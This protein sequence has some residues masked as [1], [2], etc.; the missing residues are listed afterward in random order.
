MWKDFT[1]CRAHRWICG[2]TGRHYNFYKNIWSALFSVHLLLSQHRNHREERWSHEMSNQRNVIPTLS[3][4]FL[5][6][7]TFNVYWLY[8]YLA[9]K[10]STMFSSCLTLY[11]CF[12][13]VVY[14]ELSELFSWK[15]LI[16][17][18]EN[19]GWWE[20]RELSKSSKVASGKTKTMSKKMLKCYIELRGT[21]DVVNSLWACHY[22]RLFHIKHNVLI[23]S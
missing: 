17:A 19:K 7:S 18:D 1:Y 10:F 16:A 6:S 21:A 12:M 9:A 5:Y 13:Q 4:N 20:R 11:V 23:H 15:Q 2:V 8:G 14:S 3:L 22:K